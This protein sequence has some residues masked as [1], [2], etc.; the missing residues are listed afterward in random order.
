M[1]N[2]FTTFIKPYLSWIDSGV[3][4]G[5]PFRWLY[6][7]F[8]VLNL[9]VP[10]F[11]LSTGIRNRVFEMSFKFGFSFMLLW[12]A[13]AFASWIGFQI[14]WNRRHVL[15]NNLDNTDE[16]VATPVVAQLFQTIGEWIGTWI[17]IVGTFFSL[18]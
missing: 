12:I 6:A 4:F 16:F 7:A 2:Q 11:T 3:F 14:W 8:A 10:V 1:E 15:P 17:A 18:V 13:I 9:L 5:K